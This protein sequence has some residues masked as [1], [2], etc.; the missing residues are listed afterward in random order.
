LPTF[1]RPRS[2]IV[3]ARVTISTS[4]DPALTTPHG[5]CVD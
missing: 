5:A 2:A 1:G 4:F 3:P